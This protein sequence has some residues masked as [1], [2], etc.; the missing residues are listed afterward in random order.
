[1]PKNTIIFIDSGDTLIDE[2]TQIYDERGVVTDAEFF[3]EAKETLLR[4]CREGF[5]IALVAD[6]K[7]ES[8]HRV[9][10]RHGLDGC[11]ETWTI[12][13]EVGKEKPAA[14]MF[15]DAM[16][17][18]RLTDDDKSRVVMI[19]NNLKKDVAGANRFGITSIWLD[20]SPRY[21][22]TFENED[23]VPRHTVR[24]YGELLSLIYRLEERQ[25]LL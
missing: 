14:E 11:F 18:M 20:I 12:S 23:M 21:F 4:L 13:E 22:H 17:K 16:K 19:G 25:N 15:S 9:Y 6:G 2:S 5:R 1:M 7:S 3:P 10:E 8:F 24:Q